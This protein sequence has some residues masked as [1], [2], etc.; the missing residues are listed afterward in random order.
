MILSYDRYTSFNHH[1]MFL[2]VIYS[3]MSSQSSNCHFMLTYVIVFST[4]NCHFIIFEFCSLKCYYCT[5]KWNSKVF[6]PLNFHIQKKPKT[7]IKTC[8]I[9]VM[10]SCV[11]LKTVMVN[12]LYN[13]FIL[14]SSY[15]ALW[16]API[17]HPLQIQPLLYY[18][19][20]INCLH[21]LQII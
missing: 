17:K 5:L 12:V 14:Y 4:H 9:I 3:Y 20:H 6:C 11:T 7:N 15:T 18:I 10:F 8:C 2:Y 21:I 1:F 19:Q 16:V 13:V